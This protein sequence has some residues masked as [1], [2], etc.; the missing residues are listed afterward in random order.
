M[1]ITPAMILAVASL[2]GLFP[3]ALDAIKLELV[4][5]QFARAHGYGYELSPPD[6]YEVLNRQ[7]GRMMCIR[8]ISG[9]LR[10]ESEY[11]V[12]PLG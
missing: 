12:I 9:A 6:G 11:C 2:L 1:L 3:L 5:A 7:E 8:V 4:A 10:L